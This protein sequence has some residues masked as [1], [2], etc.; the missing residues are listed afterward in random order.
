MTSELLVAVIYYIKYL[1][2]DMRLVAGS[3]T[4]SDE[5]KQAPKLNPPTW[6]R[7]ENKEEVEGALELSLGGGYETR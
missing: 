2:F 6:R 5:F 4:Q 7:E 1:L 3:I